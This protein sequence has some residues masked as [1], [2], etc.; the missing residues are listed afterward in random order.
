[1]VTLDEGKSGGFQ[2]VRGRGARGLHEAERIEL[3]EPRGETAL[4]AADGG[5]DRGHF[6]RTVDSR[7]NAPIVSRH[8]GAARC[9]RA[10]ADVGEPVNRL[11]G[12]DRYH[13]CYIEGQARSR[14]HTRPHNHASGP[15]KRCAAPRRAKMRRPGA[16]GTTN[17]GPKSWRGYVLPIL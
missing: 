8:P 3:I 13:E 5:A 6:A 10:Q 11:R 15:G 7:E 16:A 1:R 14:S 4:V 2:V 12:S 9:A 17:A